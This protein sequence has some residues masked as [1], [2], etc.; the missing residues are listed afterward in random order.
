M[1]TILEFRASGEELRQRPTRR[2]GRSAEIVIFP[3][4][5]YERWQDASGQRE[6]PPQKVTRDILKLV[7]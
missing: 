4:I 3:G 2:I 5:R 6:K 1:A 7:D